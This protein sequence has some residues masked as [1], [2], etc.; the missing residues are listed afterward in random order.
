MM[1]RSN[2]GLYRW[3]D[4]LREAF[5]RFG[6]ELDDAFS[7]LR[8]R[9]DPNGDRFNRN[10]PGLLRTLIAVAAIVLAALALQAWLR[11]GP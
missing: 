1:I 5:R 7:E 9:L 11:S 8:R 4:D 10:D 3:S 2:L 6:R